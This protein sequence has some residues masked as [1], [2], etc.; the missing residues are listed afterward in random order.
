VVL[1][2]LP[3]VSV[4]QML[5]RDIKIFAEI[6]TEVVRHSVRILEGFANHYRDSLYLYIY[7]F[8]T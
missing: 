1:P 3:Y 4:P 2:V 7:L 6:M 8:F 5:A